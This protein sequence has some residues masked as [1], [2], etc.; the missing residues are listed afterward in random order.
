[1]AERDLLRAGAFNLGFISISGGPVSREFITWWTRACEQ[2]CYKD[3]QSGTFV[4]QKWLDLA[5]ALF[6]N[7][8]IE[9]HAGWNV[10]P[11]NWG[12]RHITGNLEEDFYAGT[13]P[14]VFFHYSGARVRLN[15][16]EIA[17]KP[18]NKKQEAALGALCEN[19][20]ERLTSRDY[21]LWSSLPYAYNVYSDGT[22][23]GLA[24]R[25]LVGRSSRYPRPFER[26]SLPVTWRGLRA[27]STRVRGGYGGWSPEDLRRASTLFRAVDRIVLAV[28]ALFGPRFASSL[29]RAM[30]RY[31]NLDEFSSRQK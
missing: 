27:S 15:T 10:G 2:A 28:C 19:Y 14:L 3:F 9:R 7:I 4:D 26:T 24:T 18:E 21:S 22:A 8:H 31:G 6:P 30:E 12:E 23:I 1:L 25:R 11:W 5:I 16:V 29:L 13:Q 20:R 17:I